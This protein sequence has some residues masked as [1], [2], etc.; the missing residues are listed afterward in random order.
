MGVEDVADV[1]DQDQPDAV[2]VEPRPG[3][4]L[5]QPGQVLVR[6][7]AADVEQVARPRLDPVPRQRGVRLGP[8]GLGPEDGVGPLGHDPDAVARAGRNQASR[9]RR[10]ASETV[11]IR[12][13]QRDRGV[14]LERPGD[15]ALPGREDQLGMGQGERVVHRD[16]DPPDVPDREEAVASP[17][18]RSGRARPAPRPG[19]SPACR[20]PDR[21]PVAR[22]RPARGLADL[23]DD[24]LEPARGPS[25]ASA[26][27]RST[28]TTN[29]C[30]GSGL[31][32]RR[33]RLPGEP[34]EPPPVRQATPVDPDPH[35]AQPLDAIRGPSP[36]G[37]RQKRPDCHGQPGA[38]A[39]NERAV[40]ERQPRPEPPRDPRLGRRRRRPS[41]G[42]R[43]GAAP[44][45]GARP[46]RDGPAAARTAASRP[47][48]LLRQRG[49]AVGVASR[50]RPS[51]PTPR[52]D[53]GQVAEPVA[54]SR[55][56]TSPGRS[57]GRRPRPPARAPGRSRRRPGGR[58]RRGGAGGRRSRSPRRTARRRRAGPGRCPRTS[59]NPCRRRAWPSASGL[60]SSPTTRPISG[61]RASRTAVR[62]VPQPTSSARRPR[63]PRSAASSQYDASRHIAERPP[64]PGLDL[65]EP[66][67]VGRARR[68]SGAAV[69]RDAARL[70]PDPD[71]DQPAPRPARPTPV[72]ERPRDHDRPAAAHAR[73]N[74]QAATSPRQPTQRPPGLLAQPGATPSRA[75]IAQ[76]ATA[77]ADLDR[78]RRPAH[79][80][81]PGRDDRGR[82]QDGRQG[83]LPERPA[84][85]PSPRAGRRPAPPGR[86]SPRAARGAARRPGRARGRRRGRPRRT[87]AASS[88]R[89]SGPGR[90]PRAGSAT[91]AAERRADPVPRRAGARRPGPRDR[92]RERRRDD[93]PQGH[94]G[95]DHPPRRGVRPELGAGPPAQGQQVGPV[96]AHPAEPVRPAIAPRRARTRL[97][98]R[99]R[100]RGAGSPCSRA[101]TTSGTTAPSASADHQARTPPRTASPGPRT[102]A[103]TTAATYPSA[104]TACASGDPAEPARRPAARRRRP[105]PR[106]T[107]SGPRRPPPAPAPARPARRPPA[108]GA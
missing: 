84:G 66:V 71:E 53:L 5:D 97:A 90:P 30:R 76:P 103:S 58:P 100:N 82:D 48:D 73:V 1:A 62:P 55:R 93:Q 80:P 87:A 7:Q 70:C 68:S 2:A 56:P 108:R 61:R 59:G 17:G 52:Q 79:A 86:S 6:A 22:R 78:Q 47:A 85:G 91:R 64:V 81:G 12:S 83:E 77:P 102:S 21:R 40:P 88:G 29:S 38:S 27:G 44:G 18:S 72:S 89:P 14:L 96:E 11:T 16:D 49:Q 98:R 25:T 3:E 46:R 31:G 74:R 107:A 60:G 28:K 42:S 94:Q 69:I 9:S 106:G 54:P 75:S 95:E 36:G 24:R 10:A 51:S 43:P 105:R 26:D 33:E 57:T 4:R 37:H 35:D 99:R 63:R 41:A 34:A 8:G 32:Q 92:R 23:D 15:P 39:Q 65:G 19:P 13:A 101:W 20:R 45:S 104:R 67:E 50:G